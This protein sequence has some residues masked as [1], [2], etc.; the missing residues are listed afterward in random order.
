ME[1]SGEEGSGEMVPST[2]KAFSM[3]RA[4]GTAIAYK[5]QTQK[6]S[7]H[8]RDVGEE[9]FDNQISEV[10]QYGRVQFWDARFLED[11]TEPF[12]WYYGYEYFRGVILENVPTD[13]RVMVAGVGSSTMAEELVADGYTNV[14]AQDI[15]RV[16]I[17]QLRIRNKALAAITYETCNMTDSNLP[18][19]SFGAIIDKA[20]LDSLMCS[21]MGNNVVGQYV[22]EVIRLLA[23]DGVFVCISH[24][25]PEDL[26]SLLE[27]YDLDE[28]G[29]TP[30]YIDVCAVLKPQMLEGE[31]LDAD[32]PDHLYWCYTATK[33]PLMVKRRS[34]REEKMRG[35]NKKK[36]V[37]PTVK[38][39]NL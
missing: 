26:L 3:K 27:Q 16:A 28:P 30:W 4:S 34:D 33:D 32:N 37:K 15:S 36:Y 2:V 24:G 14:V 38:A 7:I 19:G 10:A 29:Y 6:S 5:A 20:L 8:R 39:P 9:E 1:Y 25:G 22:A 21:S 11:G 23:D 17:A 13:K 31:E 12:D 35:K 18:P